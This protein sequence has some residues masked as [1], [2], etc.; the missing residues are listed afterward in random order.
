MSRAN[1]REVRNLAHRA[2]CFVLMTDRKC[3]HL[4]VSDRPEAR[5]CLGTASFCISIYL[6]CADISQM[7]GET[8][9]FGPVP[10]HLKQYGVTSPNAK[11]CTLSEST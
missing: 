10:G 3:S 6:D 11:Y 5:R 1:W 4:D 7:T 8:K 9:R 2:G